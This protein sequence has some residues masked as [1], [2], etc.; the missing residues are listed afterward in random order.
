MAQ[1]KIKKYGWIIWIVLLLSCL[2][3]N[4]YAI[5]NY[6]ISTPPAGSLEIFL[7]IARIALEAA[8]VPTAFAFIVP[9]IICSIGWVRYVRCVPRM[10]FCYAA[11]AFTAAAKFI[12]GFIDIFSILNPAI[13]V[14][15]STFLDFAVMSAAYLVMFFVFFRKVYRFNPVEEYN[16]FR[17]WTIIYMVAAGVIVVFGNAGILALFDGS[18]LSAEILRMLYELGYRISSAEMQEAASIAA[19]CTYFAYLIAVIAAGEILRRNSKMFRNPETREEYYKKHEK[20][21]YKMRKDTDVTFSDVFVN[22]ES[23]DDGSGNDNS[24]NY[25]HEKHKKEESVFDEFD[26]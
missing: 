23:Y 7:A 15:A 6:V 11:M 5:Y 14:F 1:N 17:L 12:V 16:A 4:S 19:I 8:V 20:R 10:D 24:E 13:D 3:R 18:L 9:L 25:K 2:M 26:I 21:P 22:A